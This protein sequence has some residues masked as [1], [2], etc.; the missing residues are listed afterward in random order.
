[1]VFL[2]KMS[3]LVQQ[4]QSKKPRVPRVKKSEVTVKKIEDE[5]E[6]NEQPIVEQPV[7]VEPVKTLQ[8][9]DSVESLSSVQET[10]PE[11]TDQTDDKQGKKQKIVSNVLSEV[12]NVR[13][14]LAKY[15]ED[16]KEAKSNDV[17][18][19]LK[20]I[21]KSV[22]KIKVQVNKLN[23]TK[24][25]SSNNSVAS[26]FQKPVHIS[27]SV[28]HFTGWNV[29]E[30]RARVDVT[31]FI[32]E[33]IRKNK[34]QKPGDGRV[35]IADKNLRELLNYNEERDGVLTYATIQKLLAPHYKTIQG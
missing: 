27:E 7:S 17:T 29:S 33:Y 18:R 20:N 1:M 35:I 11:T 2:L 31:N 4:Q 12:E 3:T 5:P 21:E 13:S 34:L 32:C 16:H 9:V 6:R 30:P 23:K 14:L 24:T 26:G 28:A 8:S 15:Q 19:L 10:V 22:S 25:H